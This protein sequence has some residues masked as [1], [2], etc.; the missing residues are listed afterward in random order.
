MNF[1]LETVA[2]KL[3]RFRSQLAVSLVEKFGIS[4]AEIARRLGV[5]TSAISKIMNR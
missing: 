1:A 3:Q 5:S 4:L 2:R